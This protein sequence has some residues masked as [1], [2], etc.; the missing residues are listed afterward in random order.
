MPT[1]AIKFDTKAYQ[2]ILVKNKTSGAAM[3]DRDLKK[4]SPDEVS[5]LTGDKTDDYGG[6]PSPY[7]FVMRSGK[8]IG[9]VNLKT[10]NLVK[11][12]KLAIRDR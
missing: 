1:F 3:E 10:R 6:G 8:V 7:G 5:I 11:K 4:L 9:Y 12:T 2:K